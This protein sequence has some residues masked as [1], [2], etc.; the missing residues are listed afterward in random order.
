MPRAMPIVSLA[1]ASSLRGGG[2]F[3]AN[4]APAKA[5]PSRRLGPLTN[6]RLKGVI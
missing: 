3:A 5:H 4:T 1:I 6:Q 2:K